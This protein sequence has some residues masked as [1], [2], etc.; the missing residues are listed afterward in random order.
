VTPNNTDSHAVLGQ[1]YA[2]ATASLVCGI[3]CYVSLLGLEK[4]VL[5]LV[6]GWLA[7]RPHPAPVL[8]EHR[9]WAKTGVVLG[10]IPWILVPALLVWKWDAVIELLRMLQTLN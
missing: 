1:K 6:F 5:A 2:F 9:G 4:A 8:G 3:A 7:L 10:V